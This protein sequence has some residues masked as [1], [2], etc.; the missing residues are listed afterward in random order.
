M[1]N[2][3]FTV[4]P[5]VAREPTF[6]DGNGADWVPPI[7]PLPTPMEELRS[8]L[9]QLSV[10]SPHP[11]QTQAAVV[12]ILKWVEAEKGVNVLL[13]WLLSYVGD[14]GLS[15]VGMRIIGRNPET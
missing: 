13:R 4:I 2:E 3:Y 11:G 14:K 7:K 10:Q 12:L 8:K 6:V 15:E 1:E 5:P 9:G